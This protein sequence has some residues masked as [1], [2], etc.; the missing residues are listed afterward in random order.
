MTRTPDFNE[1][2]DRFQ[3]QMPAWV[4]RNL[5][6]LC[7]KHAVWVRVPAGVALIGGGVHY[8]RLELRCSLKT[9]Q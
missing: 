9:F 5:K 7:G 3:D 6:R 4:G 1:E 2:M 8:R